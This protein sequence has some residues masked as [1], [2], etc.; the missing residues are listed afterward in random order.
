MIDFNKELEYS[1]LADEFIEAFKKK[2]GM[3]GENDISM[4]DLSN[5]LA[6]DIVGEG[7][8]RNCFNY[9]IN[10]VEFSVFKEF[11]TQVTLQEIINQSANF[12][13]ITVYYCKESDNLDE[14][15]DYI[16]FTSPDFRFLGKLKNTICDILRKY[17]S[18][19]S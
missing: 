9:T 18:K 7:L 2:T 19:A 17:E 12:I 13:T 16:E 6:S 5:F 15:K 11:N 14:E 8:V 1:K 10:G 4:E 3:T